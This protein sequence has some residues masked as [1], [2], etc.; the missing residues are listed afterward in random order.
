M[1]SEAQSPQNSVDR[2]IEALVSALEAESKVRAEAEATFNE[3]L[4]NE[5][6]ARAEAEA[7]F[8]E[9]LANEAKARAEAEATALR[10]NAEADA[11]SKRIDARFEAHAMNLE[12]LTIDIQQQRRTIDSIGERVD[13]LT[14]NM[15]SIRLLQPILVELIRSHDARIGKL[16][17][18]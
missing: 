12:L 11:R 4:A 3:R 9:R 14:A 1:P 10:R 5:A 15:E 16:E 17:K 7:T 6:K 18:Q 13:V 2:R 8:N